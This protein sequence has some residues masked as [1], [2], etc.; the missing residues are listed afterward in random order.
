MANSFTAL[1]IGFEL[2]FSRI[3]Q[4]KWLQ[5]IWC[6]M[7]ENFGELLKIPL[8]IK[9]FRFGPN[10]TELL[11]VPQLYCCILQFSI[12][13]S[14]GY[15]TRWGSKYDPLKSSYPNFRH[16]FV[17]SLKV[18]AV[19]F[20]LLLQIMHCPM[21]HQNFRR[22]LQDIWILWPFKVESLFF[23]IFACAPCK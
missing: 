13:L 6:S 15:K 22:K 11:E 17:V 21:S 12:P 3:N 23:P 1:R 9:T 14:F 5:S 7:Q 20:G 10:Y 16:Q 4:Y 18:D 19:I 2:I 8:K